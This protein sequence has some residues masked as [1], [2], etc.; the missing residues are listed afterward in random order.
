MENPR[1]STSALCRPL[2]HALKRLFKSVKARP[3]ENTLNG[4]ADIIRR[5]SSSPPSLLPRISQVSMFPDFESPDI[6]YDD[7]DNRTPTLPMTFHER[8]TTQE[9][10][11]TLLP[12]RSLSHFNLQQVYADHCGLPVLP[13]RKQGHVWP[14]EQ[15]LTH[16][17]T[18]RVLAHNPVLVS[19]KSTL[20]IRRPVSF[21]ASIVNAGPAA[22]IHSDSSPS[23]LRR[24]KRSENLQD[25]CFSTPKSTDHDSFRL[26]K[27]FASYCIMDMAAPGCPIS[28]VSENLA[29]LY[30]IKDRFV[31]NAHEISELSM[32]LSVGRDPHG[33]EV[34]YLLLFSP[35]ISPATAK[36]RFMLVSAIDVSGYIHNA[37]SL[38]P[39]PEP[40]RETKYLNSYR[41]RSNPT[42]KTSSNSWI[43][44]RTD[45]LA[46]ELL[47]GC[48]IKESSASTS[49][50]RRPISIAEPVRSTHECEDIWTA[51]AREEGLVTHSVSAA[52]KSSGSLHSS[53]TSSF[54]NQDPP[55]RSTTSQSSL[56]YADE[57]VIETFIDSLQ[58]LY[59]QYF[60]L[61]CSPRN[62][63]FYE[64]C[65]VSPAVYA[66]GE[67]VSDHLSHTPFNLVNEFGAHLAA[68][69]RF[70][71]VIRW[72]VDGVKKQL[73]CVPL[74]G[75]EPAPW[76][77]MLVGEGTP[78][79]W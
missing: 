39:T 19:K 48:S 20:Q 8:Y 6:F 33:N 58:V 15:Q 63:D 76:I 57:K 9:L 61:A 10:P 78:I 26:V 73:Y 24:T 74:M 14:A 68:G 55:T 50:S 12:A 18:G 2:A 77:C 22:S 60:L 7:A 54:Q 62:G 71:T 47:H 21:H 35:L 52:S 23:V 34:T 31:L 11:R 51:I 46:D 37:A 5:D 79:C 67:Y 36:S 27:H 17:N 28:A 40:R 45:Q 1:Q 32:D 64:I 72:G 38:E 43:D 13:T 75:H 4:P 69:K 66:S 29:Y 49:A 42:R 44:E 30:D 65:Y 25:A 56:N 53:A 16:A 70:R 3:G 41:D 59:S